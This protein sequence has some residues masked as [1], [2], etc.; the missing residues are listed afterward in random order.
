MKEVTPNRV[1]KDFKEIFNY[2]KVLGSKNLL[3]I[4]C[5]FLISSVEVNAQTV[6][7][8][9]DLP[10][11]ARCTSNDL[12][13]V[14]AN[15]ELENCD[16]TPGETVFVPLQLGVINNTESF[17]TS[18][19]FWARLVITNPDG[20]ENIYYVTGCDA[21]IPPGNDL[22]DPDRTKLISF[23]GDGPNDP[24]LSIFE[25]DENNELVPAE[26]NDVP[27]DLIPYTCG[28]TLDL[29]NIYQAWT[30][31]SD[32]AARQCPLDPT[33][34]NP[35]CGIEPLLNIGVGLFVED[36]KTDVSCNGASD[37]SIKLKFSGGKSP[38]YVDTGSGYDM[39]NPINPSEFPGII[40]IS[41]LSGS[42][43]GTTYNWKIKDS[44][45]PA[46]EKTGSTTIHEPSALNLAI[47][48][49]GISC[50]G[51]NDGIVSLDG[52]ASPSNDTFD[53]YELWKVVGNRDDD[54]N[55]ETDDTK[56][57]TN[58]DGSDF[59]GLSAGSY[60]VI[61]KKASASQSSIDCIAESGTETLTDP[62]ALN[63]AITST[64]IS[65]NG[66]NDGIVSLDGSASPSNDTFDSYELW[67]VVGNRDDDQNGET[68]DT[69]E[70]T[71]TD[72]SDFT[73]LSAG[74]YYVIGKKASAS[75]SSIDCIAESG[76]ETLTD[77]DALNLAITSTGI[78]CNGANDGI[79]SLD[80]S[81]S[82]SN[83]TFDS[84]ELWKVVGNRDDDQNGETDDTKEDTN[85]DGSD[86]TG[87]S[88]GSYYVIGKKA[89]ASQSSIDCIAESGTETLTDP[90]ALN[91]AIT[92]TGISCNGANDG[93][94]SLD[95]S[96]SPAN[97][98]FDSYE[99]WKVVGN[100][101]DDQ[102][103]E[104]DDT[105][106]DTNT[107][108]S[109]FTGLSAGSYYVIGKKASASQ[110]S[111]DCIAESGTETLTDPDALN[112]AITSTGISCNGANDGI[113]SLDGSASPANDTF[114]SYELWKV[115]GNRD[116]DQNGETDDTKED[117]N[118]DGSDFTGLSAGSYYVIGKK[119]SASQS[120]IDCIA[121]SGTETLT[122]PDALSLTISATDE[123]C[124]G[125]DGSIS[126]SGSNNSI[127]STY[128]HY[129]VVG[130]Q[131]TEGGESDDDN[132]GTVS[133]DSNGLFSNTL[134]A[135]SYYI[136]GEANSSTQSSV[137]CY[138]TSNVV[139]INGPTDCNQLFPTQTECSDYL[140]CD[141]DK[142]VQEYMCVTIKKDK[143]TNV[144]P[145]ALFYYGDYLVKAD[146]KEKPLNIKLEQTA[147][148][149]F[150][151]MENLNESNV[152]VYEN[153]CEVSQVEYVGAYPK[154][155]KYYVEINVTP[156]FEGSL[157]FSVKLD[158]KTLIG[159]IPEKRDDNDPTFNSFLFG[160][161][162]NNNPIGVSYGSLGM[163]TDRKCEDP[164][165]FV[166][167]CVYP[168]D[169]KTSVVESLSKEN[170]SPGQS[171]QL[172]ETNEP[173][174][175]AYPIPFRENINIGY[176]FDYTT[177]VTIQIFNL[178]GQLLKTYT[179][180]AV[181]ART[182]STLDIDFERRASQVYIVRMI[183][184]REVFTKKII[185][186]K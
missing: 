38:Y 26:V 53:S 168:S 150:N 3:L 156:Q 115:V 127:F 173:M 163:N 78:S 15:L 160:M 110:S 10:A 2:L 46:C 129:K 114:D 85:T 35:K 79:V 12:D 132:L 55:G 123:T 62:D 149:G 25:Y 52:S 39:S 177:D 83:D 61:G 131:D 147:P 139:T 68:D 100:R 50:N 138:A 169:S 170:L 113:V 1:L 141:T 126:L 136:I 54:Q 75:Q 86:F 27:I 67:K 172:I 17:R 33:K 51:A 64:G 95:G 125:G 108:G 164:V 93:I 134:A 70:D 153:G 145:G 119:A 29:E 174:F 90:D 42:T 13:V 23:G 128:T 6:R 178:N 130:V 89:S 143:V 121:E 175:S 99:L 28:S 97:D 45:D 34:I 60:Y 32:N 88:A 106:E 7:E 30:D 69:K 105:K 124:A 18:Y 135:G 16:C 4:L 133:P 84:Y 37:G 40:T 81:A 109:D 8:T 11:P 43:S 111:I 47:T 151:F 36:E 140:Y 87:L 152:R 92:S 182:I 19:A 63:L 158:P 74:S 154:D 112:L 122:D 80:G 91:L 116:D 71:N 184:D 56:E 186:A 41:N 59:T 137:K 185:S 96:A 22:V 76:T 94:V 72:G 57:D 165:I 161:V 73:G 162:V 157:V 21:D 9:F 24:P 102:N 144:I 14:S 101:D 48:S 171:L 66:A 146:E 31:A 5:L 142:I 148:A 103:G 104:T 82:P 98:T 159:S 107:D 181:D 167:D 120:S 77:P 20:S 65:C 155:G 180:K 117:T 58:T 183:T 44:S 176:K 166:R 49:T 118:T 179:E